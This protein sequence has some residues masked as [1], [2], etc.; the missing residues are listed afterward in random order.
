MRTSSNFNRPYIRRVH[1][2]RPKKHKSW[3]MSF[4]NRVLSLTFLLLFALTV[5]QVNA[6]TAGQGRYQVFAPNTFELAKYGDIPVDNSTGLPQINVP[7]MNFSDKDINLNISLSYHASGIKVDQ[8]AT[9][10]GLGWALNAGGVITREIRGIPDFSTATA[11][12]SIPDYQ[13]GVSPSSYY[14]GVRTLLN[15]AGGSN[16]TDNGADIFYYN[17][18]GLA[19]KFFFDA[20]S[21]ATLTKYEDFKVQFVANG[22]YFIVTDERGI[23][24]EFK[25]LENTTS[26]AGST[27]SYTS[28]WYLSKITSPSGGEI[29]IEYVMGG[30]TSQFYQKRCFNEAY[31]AITSAVHPLPQQFTTPCVNFDSMIST[32]IPKKIKSSTGNY[33]EFVTVTAPRLDSEGLNNNQ[34]DYAV[35]YDTHNEQIKKFKLSYGYF[36]AN[37]SDKFPVSG[38]NDARA[39]LNYRLR[40]DSVQEVSTTGMQG[41]THR[42][43]YFGDNN[44]QTDDVYTLPYRLSPSQDHW[45]YYNNTNNTTIFPANPSNKAFHQDEWALELAV[46]NTYGGGISNFTYS[47]PNGGNR[48]PHVEATKAG[49][50]SKIIYPTGGYTKFEF[51]PHEIN[52]NNDLPLVGGLKIKK[53]ESFDGIGVTNVKEY[54]Y[55]AYGGS[56]GKCLA[57]ENPYYT[58]Y[59]HNY[60]PPYSQGYPEILSALGVP[61]SLASS[62][63]HILRAEGTPQL[64]LG[65]GM[66]AL[67]QRVKESTPGNGWTIF[68]YSYDDDVVQGFTSTIDGLSTPGLFYSTFIDTY[69]NGGYAPYNQTMNGSS[70]VAPFPNFLNNDWR[71]GHLLSKKVYSQADVLLSQDSIFYDVKALKAVPGYKIMP[72]TDYKFIYARYYDIGGMVRPIKEVSRNYNSDGSFVRAVKE[73]DYTSL[74]HKQLTESRFYSSAGEVI[75][76][77]YYY[78]TEYGST[79]TSLNSQHILSP[80]DIRS[81]KNGKLIS[82][83]QTQYNDKGLPLI[84]YNAE[85]G[86]ADVTFNSSS[87]YTFNPKLSS[88]YNL[89]NSLRSQAATDGSPTVF[90]WSY[91]GRYP[92]AQIQN[93]TYDEVKTALSDASETFI[94]ALRAKSEP[95]ITDFTL[96]NALRSNP[97]LKKALISTYSFKPLVGMINQT[98]AKGMTTYYEYDSFQRLKN[99]K[100]QNGD[101]V[102]SYCYNYAG[103]LTDCGGFTGG[104][105]EL[106][107]QGLME[108]TVSYSPVR[109]AICMQGQ[110]GQEPIALLWIYGTA[111]LGTAVMVGQPEPTYFI[112]AA[113]TT[114][115]PDGY[116]YTGLSS[117]GHGYRLHYLKDGVVIFSVWC[118]EMDPAH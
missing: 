62:N 10:V 96:L 27:L 37:N 87:P 52:I 66:S 48:D 117:A 30:L 26:Y 102:K 17:F 113:G 95:S 24:Y 98:D 84:S 19:G 8:E 31:Y 88:V 40:L 68:D 34:L 46:G 85:T 13:P 29:T 23:K 42:F 79:L 86:G 78:P 103:Q 76:T 106:P 3:Q 101:I 108:L 15:A 41:S 12:T 60:N 58:W 64:L 18:N 45:G 57:G 59:W 97:V 80:I 54:E 74:A 116:Y 21:N 70:C 114:Y 50:L 77:K 4:C 89:D 111:E 83:I 93:A 115:V 109:S 107:G 91:K 25:D 100:N 72:I 1:Y 118:D 47:V 61:I 16:G 44:P 38:S 110:P 35:L 99:I 63:A 90:L 69:T 82:G 56:G 39:F 5:A 53:I 14:S 9:W 6:Q 51:E 28:A 7:L 65:S 43:E 11:R 55:T 49:A 20:N 73:L 22:N 104:G 71:R 75:S 33:I 2:V 105:G 81:Y 92:V 112:D 36:E 32:I 67:Y 94:N